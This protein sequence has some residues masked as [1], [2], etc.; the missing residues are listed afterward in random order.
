MASAWRYRWSFIYLGLPGAANRKVWVSCSRCSA[1]AKFQ[2]VLRGN[3]PVE[4]RHQ[5]GS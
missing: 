3:F 5:Q 1:A 2:D 4:R